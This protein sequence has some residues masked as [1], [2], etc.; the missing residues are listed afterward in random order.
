MKFTK[1]LKKLQSKKAACIYIQ[2]WSEDVWIRCQ[3]PD[4]NSKMSAPYLYVDSRFGKVHWTPTQ[5]DMFS[6]DWAVV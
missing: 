4:D 5:V 1:A 6:V 3:F 2:S